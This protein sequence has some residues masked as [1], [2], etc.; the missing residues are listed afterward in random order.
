MAPPP[1]GLMPLY[2]YRCTECSGEFTKFERLNSDANGGQC[3]FCSSEN[4]KRIVSAFASTSQS[5]ES[6]A[7]CGGGCSGGGFT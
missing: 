4:T 3:P 2:E 5:G 1:G 7:A 6:A